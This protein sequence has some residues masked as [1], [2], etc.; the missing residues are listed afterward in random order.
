MPSGMSAPWEAHVVAWLLAMVL[1]WLVALGVCLVLL[2]QRVALVARAQA[3]LAQFL[4]ERLRLTPLQRPLD[5][6][7]GPAPDRRPVPPPAPPPPERW[8]EGCS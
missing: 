7:P 2:A 8:S 1:V 6:A 3:M 5:G 4:E